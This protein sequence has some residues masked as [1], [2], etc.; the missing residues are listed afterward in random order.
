MNLRESAQE[1]LK[2]LVQSNVFQALMQDIETEMKEKKAEELA[3]SKK[4]HTWAKAT[5]E[6]DSQA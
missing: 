6:E 5:Y 4:W 3:E 1:S 2:S